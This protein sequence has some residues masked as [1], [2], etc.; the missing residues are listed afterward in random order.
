M[1]LDALFFAAHPDDVELSCG[2]T[3]IKLVKMGKKVGIVDLTKGELGTR[4][5]AEIREREVR[6]ANKVMGIQI[7]ENLRLADGNIEENSENTLKIMKIIR[8]YAPKIVFHPYQRDRHPDHTHASNLVR[9]A[10]FYS[11]LHKIK[12]EKEGKPQEPHRPQKQFSYMQSYPFE[13]SFVIDISEEFRKKMETIK[14][15]SSQFYNPKSK[16]PST[17]ISGKNFLQFIEARAKSYGFQIGT[18]YGEPYYSDEKINL[19]VQ[20]LF[21]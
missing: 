16:E 14:C 11:G 10:A 17:F 1:K 4:G 8:Q 3:V 20:N 19:T 5:S 2:G 15:Y 18:N 7:R 12:T 21:S 9:E 13:P 6:K